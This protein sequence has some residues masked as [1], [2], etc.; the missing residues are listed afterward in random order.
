MKLKVLLVALFAAGLAV[1]L[2]V[3]A[4][5]PGRGHNKGAATTASSSTSTTGSTTTT[6]SD[7]KVA[8]CHKTGSKS[9]PWVKI[10]VSKNAVAAHLRRGDTLVPAGGCPKGTKPGETGSTG[11]STSSS[12]SSTPTSS[13]TTTS[14]TT[15]QTP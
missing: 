15:T 6:S 13:S 11:S 2:A 14:G 7:K 12:T 4:P 1:S 10:V 9:N 8:L 5:P 3:A